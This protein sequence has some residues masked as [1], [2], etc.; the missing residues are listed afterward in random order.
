MPEDVPKKRKIIIR[1]GNRTSDI[2]INSDFSAFDSKSVPHSKEEEEFEDIPNPESV[3]EDTEPR[4]NTGSGRPVPIPPKRVEFVEAVKRTNRG[5]VSSLI[6]TFNSVRDEIEFQLDQITEKVVSSFET[7]SK[8]YSTNC[9]LPMLIQDNAILD[10]P[11]ECFNLS[12]DWQQNMTFQIMLEEL[13]ETL[14]G[15]G[16]SC[17]IPLSDHTFRKFGA[18]VKQARPEVYVCI[19]GFECDMFHKMADDGFYADG[20]EY[21][22]VEFSFPRYGTDPITAMDVYRFWL[23]SRHVR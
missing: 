1:G 2:N 11:V 18:T 3:G 10:E 23:K 8:V 15:L 9:H 5:R 6:D 12:E 20:V 7:K 21:E 17:W 22:G 16:F 13:F 19:P 14:A 4:N